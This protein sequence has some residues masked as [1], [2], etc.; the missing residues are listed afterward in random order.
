MNIFMLALHII[1]VLLNSYLTISNWMDGNKASSVLWGTTVLLWFA[2]VILDIAK[3]I[4]QL[5]TGE[6]ENENFSIFNIRYFLQCYFKNKKHNGGR[7][8]ILCVAFIVSCL[9]MDLVFVLGEVE[10]NEYYFTQFIGYTY[11]NFNS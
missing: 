8:A 2:Q 3:I 11:N 1:L 6:V 5:F 9:C 7:L 10:R 4:G